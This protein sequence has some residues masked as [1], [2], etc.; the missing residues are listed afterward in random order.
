VATIVQL[1]QLRA[2]FSAS[3]R[4]AAA[5]QPGQT[6][7]LFLPETEEQANG[8]VETISPVMDAE[9]GTVQ[10]VVVINNSEEQLRSGARCL[11]RMRTTQGVEE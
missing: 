5:L 8:V 3:P 9:S 11:L 4:D 7:R 6:V 2:R 1:D 10:V